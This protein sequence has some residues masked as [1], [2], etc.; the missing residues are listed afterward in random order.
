MSVENFH[1][2]TTTSMSTDSTDK[3]EHRTSVKMASATVLELRDLIGLDAKNRT[4]S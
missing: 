3:R 4:K 1:R 2:K